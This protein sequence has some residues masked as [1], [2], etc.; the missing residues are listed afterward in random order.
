MNRFTADYYASLICVC[1]L[2]WHTIKLLRSLNM[3]ICVRIA[4]KKLLVI[5]FLVSFLEETISQMGDIGFL[6]WGTF[7]KITPNWNLLKFIFSI[8]W[9]RFHFDTK[10]TIFSKLSSKLFRLFYFT[11]FCRMFFLFPS[12][13]FCIE[14]NA[15]NTSVSFFKNFQWNTANSCVVSV[16]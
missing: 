1:I 4:A 16:Q 11:Y 2:S 12:Q 6:L 10:N 15:V 5:S 8:F 7:F 3:P 9:P 13:F 14:F